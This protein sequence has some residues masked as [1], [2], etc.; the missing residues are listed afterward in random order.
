MH[1]YHW[2]NTQYILSQW[3]TYCYEI[4]E[5]NHKQSVQN[6]ILLESD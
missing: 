3:I 5:H 1:R 2:R 4:D 6:L